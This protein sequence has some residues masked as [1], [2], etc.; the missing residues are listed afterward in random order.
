MASQ[1]LD[2]GGVEPKGQARSVGA[3]R[4][5]RVDHD[6]VAQRRRV[7][8][9]KGLGGGPRC[10]DNDCVGPGDRAADA[11]A[12]EITRCRRLPPPINNVVA[13]C[14]KR[15]TQGLAAAPSAKNGNPHLSSLRFLASVTPRC[16]ESAALLLQPTWAL[17]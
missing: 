2:T 11:F 1:D 8:A 10:G 7:L 9:H 3:E 15:C 5:R 12:H 14:A 16:S 4:V 6:L 17:R 13:A